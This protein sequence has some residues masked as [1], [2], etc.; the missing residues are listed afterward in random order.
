[1]VTFGAMIIP[2]EEDSGV[3][4]ILVEVTS[5]IME[6]DLIRV[7]LDLVAEDQVHIQVCYMSLLCT[8][9]CLHTVLKCNIVTEL[10]L[11]SDVPGSLKNCCA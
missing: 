2:V 6:E 4:V 11:I 10:E 7:A 9:T 1:M 3:M 5:R 8:C